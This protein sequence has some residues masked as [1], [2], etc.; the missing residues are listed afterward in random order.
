SG[1][2]WNTDVGRTEIPARPFSIDSTYTAF[3]STEQAVIKRVWER[4]AED[5]SPF[6]I[7]VTT[8]RPAVF[9][10]RT[11]MALITRTTDANGATNPSATGGGVAYVNVFGSTSYAKYRPA[12]IYHDNL[13]GNEAYIGEAVSHEV[14]H[15]L[16]LSHDGKT[17]GT[18]YYGGHGTGDISWGTLMGTCYNR[19]VSQWSKG[20]YYLANNSQDDLAIVAAKLTYRIDDHGGTAAT[21]TPLV[22]TGGTEV[23]A[24]TP[25]TD[26]TNANPAN[27][28][29][30]E[31][32]TDVDVLSFITG[33]GGV[34]LMANPW[35]MPTGSR[36]GN[37]DI[38]LE[39]HDNTGALLVTSNPTVQTVAAIAT[40]LTEGRYYLHVRNSAAGD[41]FSS[42]PSGYTSYGSLGQYFI[43]GYVAESSG[44][45]VPPL[46]E[47][48]VSDLTTSGMATHDFQV[49]YSDDAAV[50]VATLGSED[51]RVTGPNG[52][53]R[54]AQ[55]L[56]ISDSSDGTPRTAT[57]AVTP[58]DG[59][60]W[61]A[62]DNGTYQVW[63][64][65]DEVG[66]VEG[67]FVAAGQLGEFQVAIPRT[68]YAANMDVDPGWTL[69]SGWQYGQPAYGSGGPTSG[70]AGTAILASNLA[71]DYANDL[72]ATYATTPPINTTGSSYLTLRFQRWLRTRRS[73]TASIQVSADGTTW[74]TL[75][76]SSL[77]S[78]D[79]SWREVQY[80]LPAAVVG[81]PTVQLRW[82]LA[83]SHTQTDIG[84]NLDDV[85]VL[86]DGT[87]DTTPPAAA[88]SVAGI[89]SGGSPS[90]AC[91][92]TYTDDTAVLLASL[93]STDLAVSGPN[94]YVASAEF[95]GADLPTDGSP[96]TATYSIPAPGGTW[97]AADNGAYTLTL[98]ADA[99]Q[100]T[101]HNGTPE[102]VLGSFEVTIPVTLVEV[103]LAPNNPAWGSV[104]PA[105]GSYPDGTVLKL[106]AI[107]ETYFEF[108]EWL[109]D[110][111]GNTNPLA[112]ELA[113]NTLVVAVFAEMLTTNHPTPHWWLAE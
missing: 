36:G 93:D 76:S 62:A 81:S 77:G 3:S 91:S 113:G 6:N 43:T 15:N 47:L 48:L 24:T 75:W 18:E 72:P 110:A 107:P 26:P 1:T 44:Y 10:T 59:D 57:Y 38:L 45:I 87:V 19:N 79:T 65:S 34:R 64:E 39:L 71:G 49:T 74:L 102:T 67:A 95:I 78:S 109:G 8:E 61:S 58:P 73:D 101:V 27:K 17:D 83:T 35:I 99:V 112:L 92:V 46:A 70:F 4:V 86:G 32:N 84:W 16:G 30:L 12:W 96:I 56:T 53:D 89:T 97:D 82:G 50:A 66:D 20:E 41:P 13:G 29:V 51:I 106:L 54:L 40:N 69:E 23:V 90:H 11:A 105:S 55:L 21:A 37:L 42:T 60:A 80:S 63:Q 98:Q 85:E 94:G 104:S 25:E 9:T 52:Y 100:D 7:D 103:T 108:Q 68:V 5:Y 31:R 14:G 28:G 33:D 2:L 111:S 88:L 22:V